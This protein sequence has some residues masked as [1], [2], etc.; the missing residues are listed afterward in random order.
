MNLEKLNVIGLQLGEYSCEIIANYGAALRSYKFRETEFVDGYSQPIEIEKQKYKGVIL[1]PFPNRIAEARYAFQKEDYKLAINREKE[2]LALHGLLYQKP[3]EVVQQKGHEAILR[4]NYTGLEE[5]YPFPFSLTVTYSLKKDG[6]LKIS[7]TAENKGE[8]M[9]FGLGWH[10][11][12]KMNSSVDYLKLEMPPCLHVELNE[13]LLPTRELKPFNTEKCILNLAEH[14][15][16]DC[17]Q[18]S[19]SDDLSFKLM[20]DQFELQLSAESLKEFPYF[21]LYTPKDRKSIAI[22]PMTCAPDAFNNEMGLIVLKPFE[23]RTFTYEIRA[24]DRI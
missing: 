6:C 3:F 20:S 17:F 2:G 11:Y 21:Q 8:Y 1:A 10:P 14:N 9:P 22:E 16:D 23:K 4:Y 15:F 24:K 13:S 19:S 12:F 18:L 5:G 7:S